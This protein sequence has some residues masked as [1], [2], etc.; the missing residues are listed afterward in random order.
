[1]N[2][3]PQKCQATSGDAIKDGDDRILKYERS[4]LSIYVLLNFLTSID[5]TWWVLVCKSE[6]SLIIVKHLDY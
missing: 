1:M 2:P 4:S 3:H 6:K 5:M